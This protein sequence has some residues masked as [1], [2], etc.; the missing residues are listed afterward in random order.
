MMNIAELVRDIPDFPKPGIVF[1]DITPIFQ[2]AEGLKA[3]ID[4]F[5]ERY[6]DQGIDRLIGIESRGFLLG[7]PVAY[8]LGLGC[9]LV[10]KKGKLPWTTIERNNTG[11]VHHLSKNHHK[12]RRL[13]DLHVL[14][15]SKRRNGGSRIE[16]NDTSV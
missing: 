12:I 8:E 1:K 6:K 13:K 9:G 4:L 7:A 3:T 15:V 16:S 2:D 11:R 5:V 14:V 10:R